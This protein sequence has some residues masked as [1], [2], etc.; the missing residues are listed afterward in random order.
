MPDDALDYDQPEFWLRQAGGDIAI[1][2]V[3]Q[4]GVLFE[5]RLFHAQQAVEKMLKG[6]LVARNQPFP[7]THDIEVLIDLLRADGVEVPEAAEF[8]KDFTAFASV[9]RYGDGVIPAP[10]LSEAGCEGAA[11]VAAEA[12]E[13][14]KAEI[15]RA[16]G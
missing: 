6:V 14:A 4:E 16:G 7:R 12:L 13:W 11:N 8:A 5:H 1:A 2:R 3:R 10:F 15:A 9:T